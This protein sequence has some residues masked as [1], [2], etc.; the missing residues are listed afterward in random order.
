MK[1]PKISLTIYTLYDRFY[2]NYRK[3]FLFTFLLIMGYMSAISPD[4][5]WASR[6]LGAK[7]LQT[8]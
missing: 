5:E 4:L 7:A 8:F 3:Y 6:M 2:E 1:K